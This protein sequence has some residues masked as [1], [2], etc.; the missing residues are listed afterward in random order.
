M[1]KLFE[2]AVAKVQA[3]PLEMQE[4]A[5]RMLLAYAGAEE[6]LLELSPEEEADLMEARA[7]MQRGE[8]ATK[9]EVE[10]VF[11][12]YRLW[13]FAIRS[14]RSSKLMQRSDILP[15]G[16][17]RVRPTLRRVCGQSWL[18]F[19]CRALW[20]ERRAFPASGVFF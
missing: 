5:A 10:A 11:T 3:L 9:A 18:C 1:T 2:Q 8:F 4:E 20:V 12:K 7:E 6:P 14:E 15:C 16:H 19:N 17:R 13:S